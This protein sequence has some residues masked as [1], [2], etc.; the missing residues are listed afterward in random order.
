MWL[1]AWLKKGVFT[2]GGKTVESRMELRWSLSSAWTACP[3]ARTA[4]F[5][6]A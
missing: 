1:A 4:A 6:P 3:N 2:A 5:A